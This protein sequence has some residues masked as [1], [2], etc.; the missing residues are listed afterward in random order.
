M[1]KNLHPMKRIYTLVI[2]LIMA[3]SVSAQD[4]TWAKRAG[5]WAYDYGEGICSDNAGNVYVS[6]KYEESAQFDNVTVT[7]AGNH[8]IFVAKYDNAGALVWVRTAGGTGGDYARAAACDGAGNVYIAGEIEG[9]AMFGT[10]QVN[11]NPGT[12][13][14]FVAKYDASGTLQWAKSFGGYQDDKAR[15]IAIDPSGNVYLAGVVQ[16]TAMFGSSITLTTNAG[17]EDIFIA[18]LD[19]NG[20]PLWAHRMGGPMDEDAKGVKA[21][22]S[23]NVYAAGYFYGAADFGS[24]N[25]TAQGNFADVFVGKWDTNGTMLWL[26]QGGGAYDDVA[27]GIAIDAAGNSYITGEFNAYA[28]FGA[29]ALTTAGQADVFVVKYDPLGTE[30]WASRLGGNI[31]DRAR[32]I[33]TNGTAVAITGQ[34]SGQVTIGSHT[35]TAADSSD[36]FIASFNAATGAGNWILAGNGAADAYEDL[37]YEAGNAV[38]MTA[39]GMIHATGSYL[40]TESFAFFQLAPWTRSDIFIAKIDPGVP[41]GTI[42]VHEVSAINDVNIT[43]NPSAGSVNISIEVSK[44]E[45]FTV[46]VVNALGQ[47][48]YTE[49]LKNFSGSYSK[50]LDLSANGKGVYMINVNGDGIN[51]VQKAVIY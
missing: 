42:G 18:K 13:D 16:G 29:Q 15:S 36:V 48:I 6:G 49:S 7:C 24:T 51:K 17:S 9:S 28:T 37:G 31:I 33:A 2:M 25:L 47:V 10:V 20:N 39:A 44:E 43:P 26:K 1:I 21:D 35:V 41:T 40:D 19:P 45:S 23:G 27:W 32:G 38:D 30:M 8:D 4:F 50:K 46:N 11:G 22:A 14:V 12:N 5:S 34:Y 3:A